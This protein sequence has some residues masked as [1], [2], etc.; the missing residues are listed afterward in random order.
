MAELTPYQKDILV[1][2]ILSEA[3]GEGVDG[4]AA[5]A[6]VIANRSNSGRFP[7]DPAAVALQPKQFSGWNEGAGGNNPSQFRPGTSQYNQALQVVDRVFS[8]QSPDPTNGAIYYHTPAVSP[9]WSGAVNKYGTNQIGNHIFYNGRPTPP[10][11][12]PNQVASLTDTVAPRVAPT[13]RTISDD[14]GQMRNPAMST[15]ARAAQ[16]TPSANTPLPRPRPSAPDIV[17][18]SMAAVNA[19][20]GNVNAMRGVDMLA[21]TQNPVTPRL[22]P[23]GDNIMSYHIPDMTPTA[24][25]G[26]MGS[27][28]P[29]P[30]RVRLPDLPPSNIGQ[31]P[32][33]RVVQSVPFNAPSASNA[34]K[35]SPSQVQQAARRA[36]LTANQSYVDRA[37]AP[38]Q[39]QTQRP[40]NMGSRDSVSNAALGQRVATQMGSGFQQP[41]GW[42]PNRLAPNPIVQPAN[43]ALNQPPIQV[44]PNVQQPV[45]RQ[46]APSP[47]AAAA[48]P[49]APTFA[50]PAQTQAPGL[51]IV[52]DGSNQVASALATRPQ[53]PQQMTVVQALR[54][55]GLNPS[56]AYAVANAQAA[57]RAREN[58]TSAAHTSS[59]SWFNEVT[60]R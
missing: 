43:V 46:V 58:A 31:P 35:P 9:S 12:I 55:Q 2:T 52:I 56:D 25:V 54:N 22:T 51:R 17:T 1:K 24:I 20:R 42:V 8:G 30:A 53:A 47:L 4:M 14:L 10:G 50:A 44:V 40:M 34:P 11:E 27:L 28:T 23:G 6:H 19:Q 13:P 41:A 16:V 39:T 48:R 45:Q 5:V 21:S 29:S 26:G 15:V 3:R 57:E 36:A 59:N 33:T 49:M 38:A 18:P 60:G 32:T 7:N 37:P